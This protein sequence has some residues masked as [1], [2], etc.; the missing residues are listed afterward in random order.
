MAR[1]IFFLLFLL[2]SLVTCDSIHVTKFRSTTQ[3]VLKADLI[4]DFPISTTIAA[5]I[6]SFGL[7]KILVYSK[8]Q[9]VTATTVAGIP[10]NSNVVEFDALDGKQIFYLPRGCDYTAVMPLGD[11]V[12]KQKQN[13]NFNER[14][15]LES[16]GK[17]NM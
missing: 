7:A 12:S 6:A 11:D 14:V 1:N 9:V 4:N 16:I 5:S 17:A 8:M 10:P 2:V 15:I 3:M 13:S